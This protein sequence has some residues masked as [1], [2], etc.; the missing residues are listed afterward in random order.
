MKTIGLAI[1][2]SFISCVSA[3]TCA[4][5]PDPQRNA[6]AFSATSHSGNIDIAFRDHV[7]FARPSAGTATGVLRLSNGDSYRKIYRIAGPNNVAQFYWLDASS[8]CK[9][10]LAITQM[11]NAAWY[12]E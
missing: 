8:Q 1:T 3:Q 11:T 9:T 5:A 2:L 7:V 4:I 12:K 10:N 6:D